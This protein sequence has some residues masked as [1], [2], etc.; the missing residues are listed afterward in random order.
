MLLVIFV[1][2]QIDL[3]DNRVF[4]GHAISVEIS[5]FIRFR[6]L[7][8]KK[9]YIFFFERM[10]HSI[11]EARKNHSKKKKKFVFLMILLFD[12]YSYVPMISKKQ[13]KREIFFIADLRRVFFYENFYE[14]LKEKLFNLK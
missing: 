1:K 4:I 13:R 14:K 7:R 8:Y 6:F 12:I 11:F 3:M 5:L 9:F 2:Q 10:L